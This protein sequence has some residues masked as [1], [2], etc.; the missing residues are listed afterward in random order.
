MQQHETTLDSHVAHSVDFQV[1]RP[2]RSGNEVLN[3]YHF[4]GSNYFPV[5]HTEISGRFIADVPKDQRIEVQPFDIIG[6]SV[7]DNMQHTR[8]TAHIFWSSDTALTLI[9]DSTRV[10]LVMEPETASNLRARYGY[11]PVITAVV[12]KSRI[13]YKQ[14]RGKGPP[15]L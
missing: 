6:V 3:C 12:G 13:G 15:E 10:C 14:L 4:V 8:S 7:S 11:P 9:P 1:W 2:E 5:F